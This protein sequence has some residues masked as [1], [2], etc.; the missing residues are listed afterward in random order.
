MQMFLQIH[1]WPCWPFL[2]TAV[3]GRW[4][5]WH[6]FSIHCPP[7]I[8]PLFSPRL[9]GHDALPPYHREQGAVC[10]SSLQKLLLLFLRWAHSCVSPSP[11]DSHSCPYSGKTRARH[12][13]LTLQGWG[14]LVVWLWKLWNGFLQRIPTWDCSGSWCLP[15]LFCPSKKFCEVIFNIFERSNCAKRHLCHKGKSSSIA[16]KILKE[17]P[18]LTETWV[19]G[20][21]FETMA[22]KRTV[23]E[24]TS[25]CLKCSSVYSDDLCSIAKVVHPTCHMG[26]KG[27]FRCSVWNLTTRDWFPWEI[28]SGESISFVFHH[29]LNES[30]CGFLNP[31]NP[32]QIW[33]P[34]LLDHFSHQ[35]LGDHSTSL[36]LQFFWGQM[37]QS[38]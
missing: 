1:L 3:F 21:V 2:S 10:L 18:A 28:L 15:C 16:K 19:W 12:P 6:L 35:L 22:V 27:S 26:C 38:T 17:K 9:G 37:K 33:T 34:W 23:K 30:C 25:V 11:A 4:W 29:S 31:P 32:V 14:R 20:S 24:T 8:E 5:R 7:Q 13:L 36:V